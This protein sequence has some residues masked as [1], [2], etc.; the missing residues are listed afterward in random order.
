MDDLITYTGGQYVPTPGGGFQVLNPNVTYTPKLIEFFNRAQQP[1]AAAARLR[2]IGENPGL[3]IDSSKLS[4]RA[5]FGPNGEIQIVPY[6]RVRD[7]W[8]GWGGEKWE[9]LQQLT[10]ERVQHYMKNQLFKA[11][12]AEELKQLQERLRTKRTFWE[13]LNNEVP[14][15]EYLQMVEALGFAYDPQTNSFYNRSQQIPMRW[16]PGQG[17]Q[18]GTRVSNSF[19]TPPAQPYRIKYDPNTGVFTW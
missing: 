5:A 10:P 11:D 3:Y 17:V 1:A 13:W 2:Q 19:L 18:I 14:S 7:G 16:S 9:P 15:S 4:F 8:W 12:V 6:V